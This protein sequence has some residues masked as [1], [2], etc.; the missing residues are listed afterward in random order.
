MNELNAF[1]VT[2]SDF[3]PTV[4]FR[5]GNSQSRYI[6]PPKQREIPERLL[7]YEY[8]QDLAKAVIPEKGMRCFAV[9]DG[10]FI[11]GDF[12]EAFVSEHNLHV[13]RMV[14]STLSMSENNVDS[15]A[16]LI[17]GDFVDALD[18]IV[19]DYFFS[20][21]RRNLVPYLYQEL[22]KNDRFQFA[23]ASTHCKLCLI[24]THCGLKIVMHGS[25]NLRSSSNIEHICIEENPE[26]YDFNLEIQAAILDK[27]QTIKKSVRR[28]DLWQAVQLNQ[29]AAPKKPEQSK[30]QQ[31]KNVRHVVGRNSAVTGE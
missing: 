1:K 18:L 17:N 20:H 30:N 2:D 3:S 27:Y 12:V 7:K 11:A 5:R 28:T 31:P 10:K 9:L 16:N 8:A 22:D 23:A 15:L 21:E 6:N 13:K 25:A 4:S 19:S 29:K 26:L 14:I 24:E